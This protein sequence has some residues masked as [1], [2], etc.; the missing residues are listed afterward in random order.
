MSGANDPKQQRRHQR[1]ALPISIK[2]RIEGDAGASWREGLL[3][4][5]S[6]G[7][8]RFTSDVLSSAQL[9]PGQRLKLHWSLENRPE[10]YAFQGEIVWTHDT[11]S[12]L[13]ECGVEFFDI[14][15]DQEFEIGQLVEFLM[16]TRRPT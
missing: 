13:V 11:A 6:A 5:L 15:P 14:T 4:N 8:L 10:P 7:G 3:V 16:S 2:Y 12:R 9:F 1:I